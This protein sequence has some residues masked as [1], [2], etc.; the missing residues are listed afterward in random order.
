M[1]VMFPMYE[2]WDGIGGPK[3]YA[4]FLDIIDQR[5]AVVFLTKAAHQPLYLSSYC[6][7]LHRR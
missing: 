3:G 1:L 5:E 4:A 2:T 7:A 6:L